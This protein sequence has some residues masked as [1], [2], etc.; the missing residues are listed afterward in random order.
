MK[1]MHYQSKC[2]RGF[3]T[4]FAVLIASLLLAV[5]FV[6]FDITFKEISFSTVVLD[7]NFALYAADT[8]IECALY[9]DLKYPGTANYNSGSVFA[10]SSGS[11]PPSSG[12]SCNGE[13]IAAAPWTIDES[14]LSATTTF[15]ITFNPESYCSIVTVAKSGSPVQTTVVSAGYNTCA[16]SASNRIER[17][18]QANY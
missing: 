10:T 6:I 9:W 14:P 1:E 8:G 16:S 4:L 11:T 12:V 17:A 3:V 5:G 15:T 2:S 13:D 18:L 7:S